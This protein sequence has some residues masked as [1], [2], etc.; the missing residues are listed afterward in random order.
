[1]RGGDVI[2]RVLTRREPAAVVALGNQAREG[3][4]E[5]GGSNKDAQCVLVPRERRHKDCAGRTASEARQRS[6]RRSG[7]RS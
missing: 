3:L 7:T 1:V 5:R 4:G 6:E 2:Q